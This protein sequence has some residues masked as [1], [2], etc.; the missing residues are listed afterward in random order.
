MRS[1][2]I[3]HPLPPLCP[4]RKSTLNFSYFH[5]FQANK[6]HP[7]PEQYRYYENKF[8]E[9]RRKLIE[10]R[11]EIYAKDLFEE[12]LSVADAMASSILSKYSKT[13]GSSSRGH[14]SM[15]NPVASG[16]GSRYGSGSGYGQNQSIPVEQ[17]RNDW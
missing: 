2:L 4:D 1:G 12:Q 3:S 7:N 16:Y 8:L 17:N 13:G 6:N 14:Q 11:N 9:V 10:K 15:A 5:Q